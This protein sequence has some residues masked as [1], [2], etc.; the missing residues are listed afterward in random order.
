MM[1]KQISRQ[2]TNGLSFSQWLCIYY[3][4]HTYCYYV[5]HSATLTIR[6]TYYVCRKGSLTIAI[7]V[8]NLLE[9]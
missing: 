3:T 2:S 4:Y 7:N 8:H 5:C 6:D 9:T 1:A